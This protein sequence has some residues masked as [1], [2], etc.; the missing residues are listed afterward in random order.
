MDALLDGLNPA[1]KNAVTTPASVVQVLAPPGSGKTKT[2]TARV[3]YLI[4]QE[5]LQPWNIVVCTFTIKAAREMRERIRGFVGPGTEAKIILGTF[6]SVARRF[7]SYY[8]QEIG[9]PKNFG[10]ADTNDS[11]AIIKRIIERQKY[12]VEPGPA[13]S[14]ISKLK[15]KGTSAEEFA[16]TQKKA[17]QHEFACVYADYEE[18]LKAQG[19]LDYDDLLLRCVQLLREHPACV[20]NVQAVLIDEYQDTNNIQYELMKLMAWKLGRITIVGDPDQSIYSFRSAEIKNLHRMRADFPQ[21]IVINLENNYRSSGCILSSA[22]AVIEQDESRPNKPLIAT[23]CVG[24]QPTLRHLATQHT[25]AKWIVE[26]IHRTKTLTAG[27]LDYNDYAILLRS[28]HLSLSIERALSKAGIPYRMV[29]GIRFFDRA[30]IKIVLDYLRVI[31][32]PDHNDALVRVINLPSRKIGE[33]TIKALQEEAETSKVTLWKVILDCAQGRKKPKSK[34]SGPAQKGIETFVNI[35]LTSRQKLLPEEGQECNLFDLIGHILQKIGLEAY[36][37]A[38]HKESWKDRWANVEELVAQATQMA[39]SDDTDED[40]LPMIEGVE[41]RQD[42]AADVLSKFLVN[43]ALSSELD[44]GDGEEVH[45]VTIST[46]HS[47]KGLEW[48]VVFMPAVYDGSIPHSRAEDH[49][50]ERRLLYVG[51][52]R[53]KGLLYLSCPVKQ[54]TQD[55]TTLSKFVSGRSIQKFFSRCGPSIG[56]SVIRDLAQILGRQCPMAEHVRMAQTLLERVEDD[57]YPLTREEIDGEEPSWDTSGARNNASDPNKCRKVESMCFSTPNLNVE[58]EEDNYLMA[59]TITE[60]TAGGF[61]SARNLKDLQE[62]FESQR[63]LATAKGGSVDK[64]TYQE[65]RRLGTLTTTKKTKA[66][67]AGQGAITSFFGRPK[68]VPTTE[69]VLPPAEAAKSAAL[70]R[71]HSL[72]VQNHAPLIDISNTAPP[73]ARSFPQS[74]PYQP[75]NLPSHRPRNMPMSAKPRK[76][77]PEPNGA[78]TRYVLLSS[79]PVKPESPAKQQQTHSDVEGVEQVDLTGQNST[80]FSSASGFRPAS[81]FHTTSMSQVRNQAPAQRK[82]LGTRRTMQ[83]WTVKNKAPPRPRP[84]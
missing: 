34:I 21:S 18:H 45:Q 40:A 6:H 31:N 27:L 58:T 68:S 7:L 47:A 23:H 54:S 1:Q 70:K 30:E 78:S 19:L 46:I 11:K 73:A 35:I 63:M 33:S 80:S 67:A 83:P 50:E 79:S 57:Q 9:I 66:R 76:P 4:N 42:T 20:S 5:G 13:R 61:T 32:Q 74:R 65:S 55:D 41:Q 29:S 72:F 51:M 71:S 81:T 2:L 84:S 69:P 62:K 14:R 44:R 12:N 26:E 10:I 37:K 17:D 48:P 75:P 24:E 64:P 38:T 56:S 53:A 52:T 39:D 3:A 60:R 15:S 25:E 22:M 16:A 43:I 8:G 77:T 28:A 49:D 82:T 36:L 59:T